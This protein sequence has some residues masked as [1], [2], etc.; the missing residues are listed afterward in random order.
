MASLARALP[1]LAT[2]GNALLGVGAI[3]YTLLGN[4]LFAVLLVVA[5]VSL[6]GLDGMLA[7]RAG[8]TNRRFGRVADSAADAISFGVAPALFVGYHSFEAATWAPYTAATWGVAAL[9]IVT[10]FARLTYFTLRA[11]DKPYF[12]GVPTPLAALSIGVLVLLFDQPPLVGTLPVPF[13]VGAAL[14]AVAMVLPLPYPKVRRNSSIRA[15]MFV[16]AGALVLSVIVLQFAPS[17]ESGFWWLAFAMTLVAAAGL[18][19]YYFLGPTTVRR[20]RRRT[21]ALSHA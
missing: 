5:G 8:V 6:D 2:L 21:E 9:V 4:K 11:F 18:L 10:A 19:T 7:R 17:S 1:N 14:T 13:L 20:D 16:T 12:V 3:A 15:P